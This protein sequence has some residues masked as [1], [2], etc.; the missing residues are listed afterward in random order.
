MNTL[1]QRVEKLRSAF[2]RSFQEPVPLR[3]EAPLL[4]LAI[5][6]ANCGYALKVDELAAVFQI[7]KLV[8][9]PTDT[10]SL[11]GLAA[12][13]GR[14]VA[15]YSLAVLLGYPREENRRERWAAQC[16][17]QPAAAIA[18]SLMEGNLLLPK[19]ELNPAAPGA[20]PYA[21]ASIGCGPD[22]RWVLSV[23][24]ISKY[25]GRLRKEG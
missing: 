5:R 3:A 9:L 6:V 14:L 20:P 21:A 2:D 16:R 23:S 12:A 19:A 24:E 1:K 10:D 13:G 22:A 18:F 25:F 15:V 11:S 8:P 7:E 4:L 17:D